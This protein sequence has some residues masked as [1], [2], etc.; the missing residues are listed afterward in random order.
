MKIAINLVMGRGPFK[1]EDVLKV[2]KQLCLF[3]DGLLGEQQVVVK[4]LP[5]YLKYDFIY[6]IKGRF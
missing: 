3:A 4:A 6:R 5:R 1:V 2:L